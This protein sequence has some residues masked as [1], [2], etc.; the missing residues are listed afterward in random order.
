MKLAVSGK[1]GVGKTTI[2]ALLA[3][4]LHKAGRRVI[5]IDADPDS[6]LLACMGYA[7]PDSVRPLVEMNALI[8][9]R[10][11]VTPGSVGGMFKMNPR[12]DDIADK[13]GVNING[14]TVLVAG[15]VKKGGAGC[16]CPENTLVRSL[17]SHLLLDKETDLI[18]DMEAGVEHLSR[19]TVGAVDR[20]LIVVEPGI[21][22]VETAR[23][24]VKLGKDLGLRRINAVGNKIRSDADIAQLK[25][26]FNNVEFA[27]FLPYENGIQ[28]A[29]IR[30]ASVT[31]ASGKLEQP[32]MNIVNFLGRVS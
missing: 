28:D 12:V 27:G 23:R 17:I 24:I 13:H 19:G 14:I 20:L 18:L 30:G 32:V 15:A 25:K 9:E 10:T 8:E 31:T 26:D 22:S 4:A 1:G 11:G 5:V 6:N 21:R 3:W 29:E 2:S 16:Y 7:D